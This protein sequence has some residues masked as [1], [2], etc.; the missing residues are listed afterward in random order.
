MC[1]CGFF[2]PVTFNPIHKSFDHPPYWIH[3]TD[4]KQL[5]KFHVRNMGAYKRCHGAGKLANLCLWS[6]SLIFQVKPD[7]LAKCL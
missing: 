2:F 3:C 4:F 7:G 1:I 6:P 5:W